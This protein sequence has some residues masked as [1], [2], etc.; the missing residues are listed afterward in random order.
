M[1]LPPLHSLTSRCEQ[2]GVGKTL[3]CL[4]LIC[5]TLHQ[6]CLPSPAS[7]NISKITTSVRVQSYPFQSDHDLR[8][9]VNYTGPLDIRLPSLTEMCA[10]ILAIVDPQGLD[11]HSVPLELSDLYR[12]RRPLYYDFPQED[13]CVRAV[14][15]RRTDTTPMRIFLAN[16]TLVIVPTILKPQWQ[17]EIK[18]HVKPGALKVTVVEKE[19]PPLR[20]LISC[21]V[22]G[23]WQIVRVS[24]ADSRSCL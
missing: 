19:M 15:R 10:D 24:D 11:H 6:P 23:A 16:T 9:R 21:D 22:S 7:I 14:K 1:S 13:D 20:Y 8:Q 5:A 12:H 17:A 2:M 3:M 4:S 18:K